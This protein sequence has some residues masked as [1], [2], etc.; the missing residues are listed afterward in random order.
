MYLMIIKIII[1]GAIV[2]GLYILFSSGIQTQFPE[3]AQLFDTIEYEATELHKD[4]STFA[5]ETTGSLKNI[6]MERFTSAEERIANLINA[7]P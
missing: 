1:I 4:L 6:S 2:V 5:S 7:A 3:S